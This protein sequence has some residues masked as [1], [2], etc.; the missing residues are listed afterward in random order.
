MII[1]ALA[2][3]VLVAL[4]SLV[5]VLFFAKY[6]EK[7]GFGRYV[8]P[9]A[10]GV[11]LSLVLMELIPETV[12]VSEWGGAVIMLGFVSFYIL[13]QFLHRRFHHLEADACDR[14]G[15]ASMVLIGDAVHNFADGLVLG[16][17]FL[18]DP[19]VGVVT[20]IGLALHEVPQEIAEFG[21]LMRAGYTR[22]RALLL[23]LSSAS[24]IVLGTLTILLLSEHA[25]DWA[26]VLVGF[27][28]G[29]LLFLAASDLL[30]RVH[31][32]MKAYGGFYRSVVAIVLGFV[33]MTAI[34]HWAHEKYGHGHVH[35]HDHGYAHEE[36][37]DHHDALLH[38][39]DHDQE[40][41]D[42]EH[43]DNHEEPLFDFR[44]VE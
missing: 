4:M 9:V 30:P 15:A 8:A 16:G 14:K 32:D 43:H 22:S 12:S 40:H 10:V 2:M 36:T 5:G 38:D 28:G 27:A 11:F 29:N 42:E 25:G 3:A 39:Y 44:F 37:N 7:A 17:A 26:W 31:S 41:H 33:L 21:V 24:T 23:N 13:A 1:E 34:L 18:V 35:D 20:A 6:S 19:A